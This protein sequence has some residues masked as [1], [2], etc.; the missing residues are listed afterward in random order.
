M[1]KMRKILITL[2]TIISAVCLTLV[3]CDQNKVQFVDFENKEIEHP[4]DEI[5][6]ASQYMD[7]YDVDGNVYIGNIRIFDADNEPVEHLFY[8]FR[9]EKSYYKVVITIKDGDTVI[10]TRELTIRGVDNTSPRIIMLDMPEF[11]VC[12]NEI[13]VPLKFEDRSTNFGKRLLVERFVTNKVDGE[14]V[15]TLDTQNS[16]VKTNE[17]FTSDGVVFTPTKPGTYKISVYAWDEGNEAEA[18]VVSKVYT[19]KE[20]AEDWGELEA[21]N[22]PS[23][24]SA[25]Y[26]YFYNS[27]A[28]AYREYNP[29]RGTGRLIYEKNDA[30]D[31]LDADGNILYKRVDE[32]QT[33]NRIAFYKKADAQAT[34]YDVLAY[35]QSLTDYLF[36]DSNDVVAYTKEGCVTVKTQSGAD[37]QFVYKTASIGEEWYQEISDNGEDG[38]GTNAVT[39]YGVIKANASEN[40][41]TNTKGFYLKSNKR[42]SNFFKAYGEN[43][44]TGWL[45]DPTYDYL[46]I[47][48]LIMPKD[49]TTPSDTVSV[50]SNKAFSETQVP[51]GKWFE[52]KVSKA[53][54]RIKRYCTWAYL[55]NNST[56]DV[57]SYVNVSFNDYYAYDFYF[58]NISYAKG[59]DIDLDSTALIMGKEIQFDISNCGNLTKDDFIFYI[60]KAD[61][62]LNTANIQ[63]TV[64]DINHNNSANAIYKYYEVAKFTP[65]VENDVY[66]RKY[67]IQAMLS[68]DGLAKNN[69]EQIYASKVITVNNVN[70]TLSDHDLGQQVTINATLDG[71]DGVTFAY[72]YKETSATQWTL[73]DSNV[74]TPSKPTSYDVKVIANFG[75]LSIEKVLTKDY[76]KEIE[77]SVLPASGDEKYLPNKDLT[78]VAS[79]QGSENL[80]VVVKDEFGT[81]VIV[82]NNVMNVSKTCKY[83]ITATATYNGI[84]L[85][86]EIEIEVVGAKTVEPTFKINGQVIDINNPIA[87]GSTIV[88]DTLVEGVDAPISDNFSYKV[89]KL[90]SVESNNVELDVVGGSFVLGLAGTYNI[91]VY[92]IEDDVINASEKFEIVVNAEPNYLNDFSDS[93]SV[94]ASYKLAITSANKPDAQYKI[95]A[96]TANNAKDSIATGTKWLSAYNGKQGVLQLT[97]QDVVVEST[98]KFASDYAGALSVALRSYNYPNNADFNSLNNILYGTSGSVN[99]D[100]CLTMGMDSNNWD[101]LSTWVYFE[102]ADATEADTL[103]LTGVSGTVLANNVPYNTWYELKLDKWYIIRIFAGSNAPI[104]EPFT[105]YNGNVKPLFSLATSTSDTAYET[106]K[107]T[108]VY[109]DSMAFKTYDTL[110]VDSE[111][112]TVERFEEIGL[113]DNNDV[114][115]TGNRTSPYVINYV[116]EASTGVYTAQGNTLFTIKGKV[117]GVF[118]DSSNLSITRGLREKWASTDINTYYKWTASGDE[119]TTMAGTVKAYDWYKVNVT[120]TTT[121]ENTALLTTTEVRDR[122]R[123]LLEVMSYDHTNK[124]VYLGYIGI[125]F[126]SQVV[127]I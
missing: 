123:F 108:M 111:E 23:S 116:K 78:I 110:T 20:T 105:T 83:T 99:T 48:M 61:T 47:W 91:W 1:S 7:V 103:K 87:M 86:K 43:K 30:G 104:R 18:R 117:N 98:G 96:P 109:V 42:D 8:Q 37:Y 2:L 44:E 80:N 81:D 69:G 17:D 36:Y 101:Y 9:V 121:N 95:I 15:T 118:V 38:N 26:H 90:D 39:K 106:N 55:S 11:G 127:T 89:V 77:L 12:N 21:F 53:D 79:L 31:Y 50:Y 92:Y 33:E 27:N 73:L 51:V 115:I 28:N 119:T 13:L 71:V 24:L 29:L 107:N 113:Y 32:S 100:D 102:N 124:V 88:I 82:T 34:A 41:G 75:G 93:A 19:I 60:G 72:Y 85:S 57:A 3:G 62:L 94:W 16:I 67:F 126:N 63:Y 125:A 112:Y 114:R 76:T 45:E 97:P 5:F 35:Y 25:N 65:E 84:A 59:A 68:E 66:S 122:P 4:Y 46:S 58:D 70:V 10:G 14:Y 64:F 120:L 74:F 52:Y 40:S 56:K 49:G 6:D 22:E 54:L